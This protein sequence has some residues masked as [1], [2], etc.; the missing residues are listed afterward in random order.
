[1]SGVPQVRNLFLFDPTRALHVSTSNAGSVNAD[2]SDRTYYLA[3]RDDA[4]LGV[5]VSEPFLSRVTGDPTFV[6]SRRL[7]GE[8]FRGIAGAAVDV[9]YIRRF[10][11]ALDL[12]EGSFIELLRPDGT[13]LVS[14]ENES[15]GTGPSP[16][17]AALKQLGSRDFLQ[18]RYRAP[19]L[20]EMRISL[21]RVPGYPAV[22]LTGRSERAILHD[23]RAKTLG[24][25][26]PHLRHHGAC[27]GAQHRWHSCVSSPATSG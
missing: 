21:R 6:L 11:R 15:I 3:Q 14:R 26:G 23:W 12:G 25:R 24:Q 19:A 27:H 18:M 22:V 10:Y 16:W 13:A 7:P 17:L 1:M 9:A 8:G 5:F 20:G 4:S 2:L